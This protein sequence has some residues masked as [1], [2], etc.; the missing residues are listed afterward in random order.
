[1]SDLF[2]WAAQMI[3]ANKNNLGTDQETQNM[4][5]AIQSGDNKRGEQLANDILRKAGVSR[6]QGIQ[7]ALQKFRR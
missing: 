7:M 2:G 5:D 3:Q 4:I 6:E 1:M